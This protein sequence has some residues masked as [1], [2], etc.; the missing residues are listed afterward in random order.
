MVPN[1]QKVSFVKKALV[2]YVQRES[3]ISNVQNEKT[4]EIFI[5]LDNVIKFYKDNNLFEEYQ[6][7]LEY[8]YVKDLLCSSLIRML[9]IPNKNVRKVLLKETW[10]KING[11]FPKWKKNI[12]LRE[13]VSL[14]KLYM[15]FMNSLTYPIFCGVVGKLVRRGRKK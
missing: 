6:N 5:V 13:E 9:K 10:E 15:R 4:K 1:Y 11:T 2:H 8:V 14:K 3:S 7:E 12:Y